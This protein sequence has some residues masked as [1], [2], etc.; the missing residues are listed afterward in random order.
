MK[1]GL[2][3][4]AI[5]LVALG[6]VSPLPRVGHAQSPPIT[7]EVN[8]TTLSTDET[9]TLTVVIHGAGE[10]PSHSLPS[11]GDFDVVGRRESSRVSTRN[12]QTSTEVVYRYTLR[13]IR[14]GTATIG[15]FSVTVDGR[16]FTTDPIEIDVSQGS[17]RLLPRLDSSL[18][19]PSPAYLSGQD[20]FVEA[21]V[22]KLNPY[23]GEQVVYLFRFYRAVAVP[24]L[25]RT[26]YVPPSFARFWSRQEMEPIEYIASV[27]NR[28]YEVLELRRILFPTVPGPISIEPTLLVIPASVLRSSGELTTEPVGLEVKPLPDGAPEHFDGAVGD[29]AIRAELDTIAG[30]VDEPVTLRVVLSGRG[31]IEA[32]PDP[33]WPDM[34]GWRV[35]DSSTTFSSNVNNSVLAGSRVYERVMIPTTAGDFVISPITYVYFEPESSVYKSIATDPIPITIAP[36]AIPAQDASSPPTNEARTRTTEIRHIKPVPETLGL[37]DAPLTSQVWYWGAWFFP[38]VLLIAAGV[39]RRRVQAYERDPVRARRVEA[40]KNAAS[41]LSQ[42]E[43]GEL[44]SYDTAGRAL[45]G[46]IGDKLNV[47]VT[48]LTREALI[49]LLATR[50]VDSLVIQRVS[51]CLTAS[52]SGR[53]APS[54]RQ[55]DAG[56]HLLNDTENVLSDLEK[57][58]GA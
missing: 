56:L 12:Q 27:A 24:L 35:F 10:I 16:T 51:D 47:P 30:R 57:E 9:L 26:S 49:D 31:N 44:D 52:D 53:F 38:L 40:F 34:S 5:G 15:A 37:A 36:A 1:S 33:R 13:P 25:G 54:G 23:L 42:A 20:Y 29:F 55:S 17:A 45:A 2:V 21:E 50:G 14:P 48:G 46:Y 3:A 18:R 8:R 28:R 58:L 43:L 32:L 22:D 7:A 6:L 4:I 11:F 41:L 39:W 19:A